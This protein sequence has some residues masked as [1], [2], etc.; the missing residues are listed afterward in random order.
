MRLAIRR[1]VAAAGETLV[2]VDSR[3]FLVA[4]RALGSCSDPVLVR[5]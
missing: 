3:C 4:A 2:S 1:I 5:L